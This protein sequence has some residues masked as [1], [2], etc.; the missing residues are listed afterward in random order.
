M[1]KG[2]LASTPAQ[3][4]QATEFGA[5]VGLPISLVEHVCI[6]VLTRAGVPEAHA[7]QQ[8][9]LLIDAELRGHYSHGLMRLPRVVER[10]NNGVSDPAATGGR[11]WLGNI[12]QVNGCNGLG[13]VV[14]MAALDEICP[15][16]REEGVAIAAIRDCNH[17]GM[18]AWYAERVAAAGQIFIGLTVSEALVHPWGGRE[19][20]LGTNPIAIGVPAEPAPFILD[21]ATSIVSMGKIHDH[22]DRGDPIPLGWALDAN[23]EPTTNA[24]AAKAG[25]IAPFG[26]PKG[27]ALGLAFEVLVASLTG[28]AIGRDVTGTLDSDTV[29]NKGDV[30]IVIEP[31]KGAGAIITNFLDDLRRSPPVTPDRPVRIPGDRAMVAD[32]ARRSGHMQVSSK[33]WARISALAGEESG[34]RDTGKHN[35]V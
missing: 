27:Y 13:P 10:I 22:A 1:T 17:L 32:A 9:S 19:A 21:M 23:G 11:Q 16:A 31:A 7:T 34:S 15:R 3:S 4:A 6:A 26:G 30:F 14:A 28:A 12:L 29:C 5:S 35:A 24:S 20:M 2:P 8:L 33:V 25:A 18:L